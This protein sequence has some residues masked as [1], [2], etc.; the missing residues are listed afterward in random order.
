MAG[1]VAA[2]AGSA[3]SACSAGGIAATFL[4]APEGLVIVA[5]SRDGER[6]TAKDC[7]QE[8]S[9]EARSRAQHESL[10]RTKCELN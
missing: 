10:G 5:A 1:D 8:E 9:A 7:R 3:C 6:E 4:V 2:A